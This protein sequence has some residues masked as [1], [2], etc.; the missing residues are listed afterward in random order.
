M[1]KPV[2]RVALFLALLTAGQLATA[3]DYYA[4][5]QAGFLS[6][7][8]F[9]DEANQSD[10][11][12]DV[13]ALKKRIDEL[14]G[15]EKKR[16]DAEKTRAEAEQK[17][18]DEELKKELDWVDVSSEKWTV[19][20]GGHVQADY[21][22]WVHNDPAVPGSDY[23]QFRRLRLVADGQGYGTS[24]FRLQMTLE[25][26]T[27]TSAVSSLTQPA[28]KDAYYSINEIPLL[29]RFRI[30][31]FFVPFSL[32]QVTNDTNNIFMERS[33]PTQGVFAVDRELGMALYN[34][35]P[36]Q[37]LAW[38]SGIFL[39]SLS[40]ATK[41]RI[42]DNQGYRVSGRVTGLPYYDEPSNGRYLLH[43]GGGILHTRDQDGRVNFRARPQIKEGPALINSGTLLAD[44]YT[45]GNLEL[46]WVNGP[47]TIQSE[48]FVSNVNLRTGD[49]ENAYGTYIHGSWFLTGE[50]RVF[51]RFG[52]HGAQFARNVPFSNFFIV[53][54]MISPG[55]IE[56]K[57][58]W[59]HLD[60][61]RFNA[62]QYNDVTAGFNWYHSDRTR[63]MFDW[64]HPM[65]S[66]QTV[67]G[68]QNADILAMRFDFNW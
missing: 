34:C 35:T 13:A 10:K 1:F 49:N 41:L 65:T 19:K 24:D 4:D 38:S 12:D 44:T 28:V 32:E 59:S 36:D 46:A 37:S 68:A 54:G 22:N 45:T 7:T 52:Q 55:A 53:P 57:V 58:R 61:A 16:S 9:A 3:Q 67:F 42:D 39:D 48:A 47:F 51:E 29:G 63:M 18:K 21:I 17:K 30:G 15:K 25:P 2:I 6:T 62:G 20:L 31:N 60:L 56:L 14:E 5:E 66:S 23:F 64:I 50:S 40:E 11:P 33:I 43:V 26:D 27:D 8:A